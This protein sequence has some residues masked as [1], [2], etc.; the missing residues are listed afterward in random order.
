MNGEMLLS[1]C[2]IIISIIAGLASPIAA[3]YVSKKDRNF[4]S[5]RNDAKEFFYQMEL[6]QNGKHSP[7]SSIITSSFMLETH[8]ADEEIRKMIGSSVNCACL[9]SGMYKNGKDNTQEFWDLLRKH[10]KNLLALVE[11]ISRTI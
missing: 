5:L 2:A 11:A 3:L 10:S 1:I 8:F 9:L 4:N 6:I 7:E